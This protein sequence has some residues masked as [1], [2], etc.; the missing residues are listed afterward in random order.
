VSHQHS[1]FLK[2]NGKENFSSSYVFR[3]S[4]KRKSKIDSFYS[5]KLLTHVN[6]IRSNP[7]QYSSKIEK[8]I[9]YIIPNNRTNIKDSSNASLENNK[10]VLACPNTEKIGLPSGENA[11]RTVIN[12]LKKIPDGLLPKLT[13][14]EEIKININLF[15]EDF[16]HIFIQAL[17]LEKKTQVKKKYPNFTVSL[18]A[19][20]DPEL[21][22]L[23]QL[24]DDTGFQGQRREALLNP[25]FSYFAVSYMK[26]KFSRF[27]ALICYA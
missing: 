3:N 1:K 12:Y 5:E 17:I 23:L 2:T 19:I 4:K 18:D 21:S 26:D 11:F 8:M 24:V 14:N 6:N 20:S 15:C 10:F 16:S 7:S 22:A 9:T 25:K 27:F 13:W